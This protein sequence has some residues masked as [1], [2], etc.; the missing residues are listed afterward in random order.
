[1]EFTEKHAEQIQETHDAIIEL[2][3]MIKDHHNTLYGNGQ[4][5]LVKD[6]LTFKTQ[7]KTALAVISIFFT[8][9]IAIMRLLK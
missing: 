5:G 2:G 8:V 4:P 3:P 9:L 6:H 1:M 7:A